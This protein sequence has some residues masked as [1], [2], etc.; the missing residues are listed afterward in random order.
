M[1]IQCLGESKWHLTFL[2]NIIPCIHVIQFNGLVTMIS[3]SYGE[4]GCKPSLTTYA[5]Y[6]TTIWKPSSN[7]PY[8]KCICYASYRPYRELSYT[9]KL[10][11]TVW[12][13]RLDTECMMHLISIYLLES[14]TTFTYLTTYTHNWWLFRCIPLSFTF[15][16]FYSK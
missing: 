9:P 8:H 16:I 10:N 14:L 1:H 4:S 11:W 2:L 7:S 15:L 13:I 5:S 6:R 3:W 12:L